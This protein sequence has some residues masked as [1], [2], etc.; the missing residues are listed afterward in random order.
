MSAVQKGCPDNSR[1]NNQRNQNQGIRMAKVPNRARQSRNPQTKGSH[2]VS[3]DI[4][5]YTKSAPK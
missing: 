2:I 1:N 5:T 3:L 4:K